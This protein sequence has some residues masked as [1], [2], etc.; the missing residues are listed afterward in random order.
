MAKRRRNSFFFA[1]CLDYYRGERERETVRKALGGLEEEGE[2]EGGR[3][4]V[5]RGRTQK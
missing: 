2:P 4:S 1:F 5:G 3:N